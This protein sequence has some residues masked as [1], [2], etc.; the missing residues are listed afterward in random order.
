M[1]DTKGLAEHLAYEIGM[2]WATHNLLVTGAVNPQTNR[3]LH[4][5]VLESFAVHVRNLIEFFY[6][7]RKKPDTGIAGDYFADPADW[8]KLTGEKPADLARAYTMAHKQISH[9]TYDR[10][11]ADKNWFVGDLALRLR[12][13]V[14]MFLKNAD[15]DRLGPE[16]AALKDHT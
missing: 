12:E 4:D 9:L 10:I 5:A 1:Y 6:D 16:L 2:V 15:P 13:V 3:Q 8:R 11:G 7:N 14:R